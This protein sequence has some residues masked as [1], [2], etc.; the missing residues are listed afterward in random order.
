[1]NNNINNY[2]SASSVSRRGSTRLRERFPGTDYAP[3]SPPP[4]AYPQHYTSSVKDLERERERK[5]SQY[6]NGSGG[7]RSN[8]TSGSGSASAAGSRDDVWSQDQRYQYHRH[9]ASAMARR[10]M[11]PDNTTVSSRYTSSRAQQRRNHS[12]RDPPGSAGWWEETEQLRARARTARPESRSQS[13]ASTFADDDV[14]Q[15]M[16]GDYSHADDYPSNRTPV[17]VN[18]AAGSIRRKLHPRAATA[19]DGPMTNSNSAPQKLTSTTDI[20]PFSSTMRRSRTAMGFDRPNRI[21][22]ISPL[23]SLHSAA[24]REGAESV[25][26][27]RRA[28]TSSRMSTFPSSSSS[29]NM[30][31]RSPPKTKDNTHHRL[32]ADAMSHYEHETDSSA[33][34]SPYR[35]DGDNDVEEHVRNMALLSQ[36]TTDLNSEL[37][38]LMVDLV[39]SQVED[40]M[41]F[42]SSAGGG[43]NSFASTSTSEKL[44]KKL[45]RLVRNSDEQVRTLTEA[46]LSLSRHEKDVAAAG[47]AMSPST[48]NGNRRS[49]DSPPPSRASRFRSGLD[50]AGR[51]HSPA[52]EGH[53]RTLTR[54]P[55]YTGGSLR[56]GA[57]ST[58][59]S[60]RSATDMD[61]TPSS[62]PAANRRNKDSV[63]CYPLVF[64]WLVLTTFLLFAQDG[65]VRPSPSFHYPRHSVASTSALS[66]DHAETGRS[67]TKNLRTR[68]ISLDSD[69]YDY[70]EDRLAGDEEEDATMVLG[71]P[72]QRQLSPQVSRANVSAMAPASRANDAKAASVLRKGLN[73]FT[74]N[75]RRQAH[76]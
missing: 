23:R 34:P 2:N 54:T 35:G 50:E 60:R 52:L 45:G 25:A 18:S 24:G 21:K 67:P 19:L 6:S 33:S 37:R 3:P 49:I 70:A 56:R 7:Q 26:D 71:P 4:G 14:S 22:P 20:Q 48:Y 42:E 46:L 63:S 27:Y 43:G 36:A 39:E 32:L 74:R 58:R 47:S 53:D 8:A 64:Q 61:E 41:S 65:T 17:N 11:S 9:T 72:P 73:T 59:A 57:G 68:A 66:T 15:E 75:S 55:G 28:E 51:S 13:R 76:D 40:E 69:H 38:N 10:S 1:M 16:S 31:R 12:D 30:Q 44:E 5:R 62:R 29:A